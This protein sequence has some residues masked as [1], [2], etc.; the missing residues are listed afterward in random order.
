MEIT[1]DTVDEIAT[2]REAEDVKPATVNRIMALVRAILR[3]AV[4][5]WEWIDKVPLVRM[6]K[7]ESKRIP[8]IRREKALRL[9]AVLPPRLPAMTAFSLATA[10]HQSKFN[11]APKLGELL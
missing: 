9:L 3:K 11:A 7:V 10:L 4:N 5:E 6:R 1:S 2:A 8:W